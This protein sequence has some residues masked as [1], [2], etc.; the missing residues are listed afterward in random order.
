MR[1]PS[2][3]P[4]LLAAGNAF[5]AEGFVIGLGA[6]GDSADGL[7]GIVLADIGLTEKTWLSGSIGANSID[8]PRDQSVDT[9]YA[10]LGVDHFFDPVGVR[11]GAAYWGD[12]DGLDSRD[13]RVSLYW[14][15]ERAM[16]SGDYEYRDFEFDLP[17]TDRFSGRTVDFDANGIGLSTRFDLTD[18]LSL[19]ASAMAYDYGVDLRLDRNR[20][21]LELLSFSRLSLIN[22]L[23]DHR[24]H[25]ALGLD[26]GPRR[27]EFELGTSEGAVDGGESRSV[28]VRLLTPLGSASDVEFGLGLDDSDLYGDVTFFSV[29]LYFYGGT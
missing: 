12:R 13:R 23:V 18:S 14:R 28:T 8:L 24:A 20:A 27:W 5:A 15:G 17:S 21:I 16:L 1:W 25:V 6:E 19:R 3:L 7:A 2:I 26:A 9:L 10:D 22:S 11:A 29:F 4:L